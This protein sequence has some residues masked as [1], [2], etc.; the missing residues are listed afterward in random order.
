MSVCNPCLET[1]FVPVCITSL[2]IGTITSLTTA[3]FIY[4][5]DT[6]TKKVI[7]FEETS[8]G[9]GLVTVTGLDTSPDFMPNHSYEVWITLAS[10]TSADAREDITVPGSVPTTECIAINFEYTGETYTS[11]TVNA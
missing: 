5:K 3:V 8:S 6:A 1:D 2:V 10:A 7:R 9:A 11:I 4:F